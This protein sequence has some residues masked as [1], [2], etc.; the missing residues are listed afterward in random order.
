VRRARSHCTVGTG[1][2]EGIPLSKVEGGG[3]AP[4]FFGVD[5]AVGGSGAAGLQAILAMVRSAVAGG[6][7]L[8]LK[9][10]TWALAI[11]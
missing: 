6:D 10:D 4:S 3:D 5:V 11:G 1:G 8:Q 7:A 2:G 9:G